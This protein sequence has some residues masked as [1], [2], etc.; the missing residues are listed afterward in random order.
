[1]LKFK[2]KSTIGLTLLVSSLVLTGSFV[3]TNAATHETI[4]VNKKVSNF[5]HSNVLNKS[6]EMITNKSYNGLKTEYVGNFD[7]MP[8]KFKTPCVKKA[9][10]NGNWKVK[11]V[12]GYNHYTYKTAPQKVKARY[13]AACKSINKTPND[14][15]VISVPQGLDN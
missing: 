10:G 1:M 13:K 12:S 14:S 7:N 9:F 15:D 8:G 2:R 5:K 6:N 4:Q 11:V 3:V